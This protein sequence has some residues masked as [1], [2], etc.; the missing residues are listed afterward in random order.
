MA[1]CYNVLGSHGDYQRGLKKHETF[2]D[3][4][5]STIPSVRMSLCPSV[6][7][8]KVN[9]KQNVTCNFFKKIKYVRFCR[10]YVCRQMD[11]MSVCQWASGSIGQ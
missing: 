11:N 4:N 3:R 5:S 2:W 9:V 10:S 7:H 6:T 1:G 8:N